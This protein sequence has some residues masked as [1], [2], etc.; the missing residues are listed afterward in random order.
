MPTEKLDF[1]FPFVVFFYGVLIVFVTE[2][3][4]LRGLLSQSMTA[5]KKAFLESLTTTVGAHR[6]LAWICFWVGGF[7]SLQNLIF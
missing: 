7:W 3:V 5:E 4:R 2:G 1:I 6:S